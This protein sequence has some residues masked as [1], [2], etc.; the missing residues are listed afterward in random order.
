MKSD[1]ELLLCV[2]YEKC[3]WD[4]YEFLKGIPRDMGDSQCR[5]IAKQVPFIFKEWC[6]NPL[7][8]ISCLIYN[9]Y[10]I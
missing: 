3:D 1:T 2:L 8:L 6:L 4:L 9:L 10:L 7:P 5:K